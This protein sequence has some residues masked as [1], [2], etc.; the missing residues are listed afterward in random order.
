MPRTQPA[1]RSEGGSEKLR[2]KLIFFFVK[3]CFLFFFFQRH[4]ENLKENSGFTKMISHNF[5]LVEK[6]SFFFL[7][8]CGFFGIIRRKGKLDI[9]LL[10]QNRTR[11][12]LKSLT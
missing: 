11:F 12:S 4:Q 8:G 2:W 1:P 10:R 6:I 3:R 5:K 9:L 7:F